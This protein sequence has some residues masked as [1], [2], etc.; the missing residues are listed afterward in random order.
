MVPIVEKFLNCVFVFA[1][2]Q[3]NC[4]CC[5]LQVQYG[6]YAGIG[7]LGNVLKVMFAGMLFWFFVKFSFGRKML[8][9]V[10]KN[11]M[12]WHHLV[13]QILLNIY[14]EILC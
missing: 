10:E 9:K 5:E 3:L 11:R 12:T 1:D 4:F 14:L 6:A 13:S 2:Q 7:S 8:I